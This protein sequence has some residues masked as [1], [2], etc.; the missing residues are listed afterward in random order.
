M[1]SYTRDH[2]EFVP[3]NREKERE[4]RERERERER[5]KLTLVCGIVVFFLWC[6]AFFVCGVVFCVLSDVVFCVLYDVVFCALVED[7]PH[8]WKISRGDLLCPKK[9]RGGVMWG[10]NQLGLFQPPNPLAWGVEARFQKK[11]EAREEARGE[12]EEEEER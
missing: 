2:Q 6:C 1:F 11:E 9:T 10:G 7:L 4:E 8:W 3:N 5:E 12:E